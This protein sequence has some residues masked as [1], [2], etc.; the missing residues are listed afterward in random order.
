MT[1]VQ[2]RRFD[3]TAV[4]SRY[5]NPAGTDYTHRTS[6]FIS[7]SSE[8]SSRDCSLDARNGGGFAHNF[9]AFARPAVATALPTNGNPTPFKTL[10]PSAR[11]TCQLRQVQEFLHN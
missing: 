4:Q 10:Q 7:A 2:E 3:N 9:G 11:D 8:H 5:Q 6:H 1:F